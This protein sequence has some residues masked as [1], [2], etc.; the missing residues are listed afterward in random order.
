MREIYIKR[1][2]GGADLVKA[3]TVDEYPFFQLPEH[4][5]RA[6]RKKKL[7][8]MQLF[9]TF[10]IETTTIQTDPD[11]APEGFMY[12]WQM[13]IGG[14][15]VYGRR[16]EEWL[17]LMLG[18]SQWLELN[19]ERRLVVYVFNLGYEYQFIK[20]FL[21]DE[22]G[23]MEV[24]ALAR[25]VPVHVVCGA[26][27]EFRCAYKLTN[28]NLNKATINELGV[29]HPKA[30]GDLDYYKI[31]TAETPLDDTEFGYCISDVVSLYEL[32]E[33]RLINENDTLDSIPLTSTGY[34]RRVTRAACRK[35]KHYRD[36]VFKKQKMSAEVY[37]LLKEA[38]RGG[39]THANRYMAGQIWEDVDS[40]D[41]ASMYPAMQLLKSFPMDKFTYYGDID[42]LDE[43][44]H[45]TSHYACLFRVVLTDVHIKNHVPVPYIPSSKLIARG[46]GCNYDNGRLLNAPDFI[47]L[48]ITDIDWRIIKEQY[49]FDYES[50]L[51]SDFY[52]ARYGYLP[53]PIRDTVMKYFRDKTELKYR[54]SIETDPEEK[55]NLKYLYAKS[56]NR[57]NAIF[58]MMYT[59]PV[60]TEISVS[61][62]GEWVEEIPSVSDALEKFYKSRNSF[63]VYAWGVWTTSAARAHL[64][65]LL[66]I[67]GDDT[68]YCDTDSDK[69]IS[70]PEILRRLDLLNDDIKRECEERGA[71]VDVGGRR[72]YMGIFE[73]ETAGNS[74][75][76]FVTLGAKKYAYEDKDGF[77]I[78]ISGVQK[79]KGA[80]EMEKIENFRPGFIFRKA[81]GRTLYYNDVGKHTITVDGCTMTTASNIGM[82]DSTYELGITDE[83]AALTGIN[84]YKEVK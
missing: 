30:V 14:V 64:Q 69:F 70:S 17:R 20:D 42:D 75:K 19:E 65:R 13:D 10:D 74:Y 46:S 67:T 23:G 77:H 51:I 24:F 5:H 31:R 81:G 43:L 32:I 80:E 71:F 68:L 21:F 44:E 9:A 38:G 22:L 15:C 79:D 82:V 52:Y 35:D 3:L 48:T 2:D 18:M 34:V 16:W 1:A 47:A 49:D 39:N 7:S 11:E 33:R 61:K 59:N 62:S 72:Y 78:T 27:F 58:G 63:L 41:A 55:K 50:I 84:V 37:T 6:R 40:A 83:Y 45:M 56:K 8:Y 76:R 26:G 73:L 12:H 60:R 53:Q 25:R 4:T 57:L 36:R 29:I 54:I 66:D 28:M